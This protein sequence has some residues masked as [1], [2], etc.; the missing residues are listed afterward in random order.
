M[1]TISANP[2]Q[3]SETLNAT[4]LDNPDNWNFYDPA[5]DGEIEENQ[6]EGTE[7]E[8]K[9]E[10]LADDEVEAVDEADAQPV[11]DDEDADPSEEPDEG[12]PDDDDAKAALETFTLPSGESVGRDELIA[13]YMKQADYSRK[14]SQ[15][16]ETRKAVEQQAVRLQRQVE[17]L[18]EYLAAQLPQEPDASLAYSD[19]Q[20]YTAQK[21]VYDQQLGNLQKLLAMAETPQS[22]AQEL[23]QQVTQEQLQA[24]NAK[25]MAA[26]PQTAQPEGR[27]EFFNTAFEA[28]GQLGF[29]ND[30]LKAVTDSRLLGLAYY[31]KMGM[32][33]EQ[34][35]AKA[36][37]KVASAPKAPPKRARNAQRSTDAMKKLQKSGSI[38]DAVNIDFE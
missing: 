5:E 3:G 25:L 38:H 18:T 10:T 28:A 17:T 20:T 11:Q 9:A 36:K 16:A 4:S 21:A 13:G 14:T 32:Q 31:A 27:K 1:Q 29:S 12:Q 30:E 19:P 23:T 37:Q 35:K 7:S 8:A 15:V 24:E 33:A 26:F 6:A 22:V 2:D 34:A